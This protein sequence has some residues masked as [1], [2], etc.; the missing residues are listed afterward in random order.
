MPYHALPCPTISL[1]LALVLALALALN[2]TLALT[3]SLPKEEAQSLLGGM[4]CLTGDTLLKMLAIYLRIRCGIPAVLMG[5]CGC[6]KTELVKYL[7]AW[8]GVRLLILNVHG[9]TTEGDITATFEEAMHLTL[10]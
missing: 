5:E 6:G 3:L 8:L 1:A 4:Y 9:G 10:V 2:L 7:C